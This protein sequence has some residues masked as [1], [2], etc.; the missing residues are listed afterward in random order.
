LRSW[1]ALAL[2]EPLILWQPTVRQGDR[3]FID[4][5]AEQSEYRTLPPELAIRE[6]LEVDLEDFERV[7]EFVDTYG[8]VTGGPLLP[9]TEVLPDRHIVSALRSA[10]TLALHALAY[11]TGTDVTAAAA[12]VWNPSEQAAWVVSGLGHKGAG[13]VRHVSS[14]DIAFTPEDDAWTVFMDDLNTGLSELGPRLEYMP[15]SFAKGETFLGVP[16]VDLCTGVCVQIFNLVVEDLPVHRCANETCQR[17]FVRQRDRAEHGQYRTSGVLYCSRACA[18]AVAR[19]AERQRKR[20]EGT[21][22]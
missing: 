13:A 7:C 15:T 22:Q 6:L 2:D 8:L 17:S 21:K 10:R 1:P 12:D 18:R 20:R 4:W 5:D 14:E 19:R 3:L 11:A 16:V 9:T